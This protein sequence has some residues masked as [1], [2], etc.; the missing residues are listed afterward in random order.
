LRGT[1]GRFGKGEETL[2]IEL[3]MRI[4]MPFAFLILS[5]FAVSFGWALRARY[6]GR[7]PLLAIIFL[8]LV[9]VAAAL[10][11]LMY[12][13]AHRV[14]LGFA[15]LAGG[16]PAALLVCAGLQLALLAAALGLLAG[17]TTG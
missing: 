8:P 2:S 17:Q 6:L 15:V 13:H 14:I 10:T 3:A 16:L 7:P 12:V 9:P 4:L 1:L 11:S 5:F